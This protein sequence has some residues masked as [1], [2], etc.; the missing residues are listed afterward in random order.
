MAEEAW[1]QCNESSG[2]LAGPAEGEARVGCV[3]ERGWGIAEPVP[4]SSDSLFLHFL[5]TVSGI[6]V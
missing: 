3:R 2:V 4:G 5:G 6:W 1:R